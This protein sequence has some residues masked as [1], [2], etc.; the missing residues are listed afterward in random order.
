MLPNIR[1]NQGSSQ[2]TD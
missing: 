2:K 1:H